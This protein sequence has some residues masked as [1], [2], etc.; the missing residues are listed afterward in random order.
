MTDVSYDRQRIQYEDGTWA[1]LYLV[2]IKAD[3][4]KFED[5]HPQSSYI[6]QQDIARM[7]YARA[8]LRGEENPHILTWTAMQT[9]RRASQLFPDVSH[10]TDDGENLISANSFITYA[11]RKLL[12]EG[13]LQLHEYV[14]DTYEWKVEIPA[15]HTQWQTRADA[16]IKWL[17]ESIRLDLYPNIEQGSYQPRIFKP[18]D[19]HR[20]FVRI[21]RCDFIRNFVHSLQRQLAFNT[22]HFLHEHDDLMSYHSGYG[23]AVGLLVLENTIFRPPLYKRGCL[24]Y[25]GEKWEL[26]IIG[27]E[28]MTI[29]V[30]DDIYLTA[31]DRGTYR[32]WVNPGESKPITVFTRAG[33][34]NTEAQPMDRTP[35]EQERIEL[36]IV[37]RQVVSWKQGGGLKIPQNGFI[38]SI[39]HEA[40]PQEIIDNTLNDAWIEYAFT[41]PHPQIERAIQAGPILIKD[42]EIVLDKSFENEEFW[43]S[44][45]INHMHIT[46]ISPVNMTSDTRGIRK[47]RTGLA[48]MENGDILLISIDGCETA[49]QTLMDSHGATLMEF[50]Q[51]AKKAGAIYML[52][53]SG[54]GSS[55]LFIHG[56]LYN[57]PS[58]RRGHKGVVYERMIPSIGVVR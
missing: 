7:H 11:L 51:E 52:N 57:I 29:I 17:E 13:W 46:G 50:A 27:M 47:A 39:A 6:R 12:S 26:E 33:S 42:G 10:L 5:L 56:G 35:F 54:E 58:E 36:V 53:L 9:D 31:N 38:L 34:I 14:G 19:V 16:I 32:F 25:T 40:L 49:Y 20:N 28:D 8:R 2:Q 55:Q 44:R 37:N 4:L 41:N 24:Y 1:E 3:A 48:V 18:F 45:I 30:P 23:D 15:Q 22:S 43:S 21:G